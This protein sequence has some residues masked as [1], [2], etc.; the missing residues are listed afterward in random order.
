MTDSSPIVY[1]VDDDPSVRRALKR[2]LSTEGFEA[3]VFSSAQ[4]F[5]GDEAF[6]NCGCAVVDVCM[7]GMSGPELCHRVQ[8]LRP[9]LPVIL[10]TGFSERLTA[11]GA[12]SIGIREYLMKPIISKD[13][14][15]AI[16]KVLETPH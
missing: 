9:D 4:E 16:R 14:S 6:S 2:T 15:A 12:K 13:L 1:I 7:P 11:N 8:Q 10:C 5:L 3:V